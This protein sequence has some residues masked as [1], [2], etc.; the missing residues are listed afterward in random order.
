MEFSLIEP[1]FLW[2]ILAFKRYISLILRAYPKYPRNKSVGSFAFG[3]ALDLH[4][5]TYLQNIT[6]IPES[7]TVVGEIY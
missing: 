1:C 7:T 3:N 2:A 5:L 6:I 4:V